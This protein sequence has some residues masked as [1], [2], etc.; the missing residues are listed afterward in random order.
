LASAAQCHFS[1][2]LAGKPAKRVLKNVMSEGL[3]RQIRAKKRSFCFINEHFEGEFNALS[4]S[5][6]VFQHPAGLATVHIN[7]SSSTDKPPMATIY[8]NPRC[9]KSRAALQLLQASALEPTVIYYLDNPPTADEL[10]HLLSQLGMRPAELLRRGESV[11]KSLN[12]KDCLDDDDALIEAMVSNPILIE[13]PV[14]IVDDQAVIGRP[15]ER[16]V[17][18]LES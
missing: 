7:P 9:S 3:S 2:R 4:P 6:I 12:L 5:A 17:E 15:T 18:L 16:V 10:R 14:V 11:Y 1:A 8:H 13:R